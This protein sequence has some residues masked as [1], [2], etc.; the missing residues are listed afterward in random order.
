MG[1]SLSYSYGQ[2]PLEPEEIEGL[3]ITSI[4]TKEELDEWEQFN[5]EDALQWTIGKKWSY[6]H[7]LSE[8]FIKELHKHMFYRVWKWQDNS[9]NQRKISV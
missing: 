8:T 2:T 1:L 7:L 5:M 4:A 6:M 9:D 3:K